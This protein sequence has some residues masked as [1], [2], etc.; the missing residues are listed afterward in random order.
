ME[1]PIRFFVSFSSHD[2]KYVREIMAALKGQNINF[3]DYS[4]IIQSIEAGKS[5]DERLIKEIDICTH[6]IV[7][8][9]QNSTDSKK[10]R[11]C[12]FELEYAQKRSG[13]HD[14]QIIPVL[15]DSINLHKLKSPYNTFENA[16]YLKLNE[17]PEA[18][19]NFTVKICHLIGKDYIP[20]IIAHPNLPFWKLFRK[21]I[22]EMDH[23]NSDHVAIM[24]ILGEFNEH[25]H[26]AQ[27]LTLEERKVK[28]Q[29]VLFLI[30]YFLMTCEY[31]VTKYKPFY[32]WIVKAVCET[33]LGLIDEAMKS[34][35]KA[36][37][38][39][40]KNQD[41]IGGIGTLFFKTRQYQKAAECFEEIIRIFPK[42]ETTNAQ[43]NLIITKQSM[44]V[45]LTSDEE[46][47]LFNVSIEPYSDDL[48]TAI[49]N[50]RAVQY[51]IKRDYASLENSCKAIIEKNL[52]DNITIRLLQLSYLNRGMNHEAK[53]VIIKALKESEKNTRLNKSILQKFGES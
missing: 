40:P 39:H 44:E 8:I 9:S 13:P 49:L 30:T 50:A 36:K 34:Y 33:D 42:E 41:V 35:E 18:I 2:L 45:Q 14:L 25:Y 20:P 7:V 32:P 17:T 16:F 47:F 26:N 52:H 46:K 3:W 24:I 31:N 51:R 37:T 38:I 5:I 12:R 22:E 28:M 4:D 29:R 19:V 48:K 1:H 23:S 53:Q 10:G 6:I 43:I 11:F 15:I 27:K 21:E